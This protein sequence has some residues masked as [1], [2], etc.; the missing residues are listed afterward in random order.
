VSV[1]LAASLALVLAVLAAIGFGPALAERLRGR[2]PRQRRRRAR[3]IPVY[4]PAR[5]RR[6]ELRARELLRSIVSADD[7]AMYEQLGFLRVV[8]SADGE[9]RAEYGYLVYPHRPIV[10]YDAATGELLSEYCVRFPDRSDPGVGSRL[11]DADDVLAKWMALHGDERALIED[12]NM[13]LPGRQ[14]DPAHVRRDLARLTEW[15]EAQRTSAR[16]AAAVA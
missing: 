13:H 4:D 3:R 12:A 2:G 1:L 5:E 9:G 10:A 16:R 6:A 8:R 15:E 7:F 14:H 11:P